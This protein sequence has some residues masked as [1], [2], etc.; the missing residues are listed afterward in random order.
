MLITRKTKV[1]TH[2]LF[3]SQLVFSLTIWG[4]YMVGAPFLLSMK[5]FIDNPA[6]I[7]ILLSLD[8]VFAVLGGPFVSW[9][10][11][12]IWTRYGRRK[13]LTGIADFLKVAIMP[14]MPFA[15]DMWT[16]LALKWLYTVISSLSSANQAL[17]MEVIP[18]SQRGRGSAFFSMQINF[19]NLIFW[20]IV[21]GRFDDVYF[22]GPLSNLMAL[23]G[24]H[25]M[26]ISA[27]LLFLAVGGYTLLGFKEIKP[28]G[29]KTLKDERKPGE[30]IVRLF[31]RSFFSDIVSRD[32]LPLYLLLFVGAMVGVGLGVLGPLLYTEQWGYSTQQLGTNVAIGA[33]INIGIAFLAGYFADATSKM[34]VYTIAIIAGLLLRIVWVAYV[35]YKPDHRPELWEILLFG[36]LG[37]IAGM[38]AG[39]VSFPLILE[40]VERN[41]LGTAGAGMG[42]FNTLVNSTLAIFIGAWIVWWSI[43]FLPQAGD[44]VE[45]V[46]KSEKTAPALRAELTAGGVPLDQVHLHAEHRPGVDGEASRHWVIRR[47]NERSAELQSQRKELQN[48]ITKWSTAISSP[49]NT[50][51]EKAALQEKISV[52]RRQVEGIEIELV[53]SAR[54]F[55]QQLTAAVAPELPGEGT[56]LLASSVQGS[57]Y[58][59]DVA[60]VEPFTPEILADL[61]K[62]LDAPD[63]ALTPDPASPGDYLGSYDVTALEAPVNGI[64]LSFNRDPRLLALERALHTAGIDLETAATK[65]SLLL[66]ILRDTLGRPVT[67][68]SFETPR[69]SADSPPRLQLV[70][71]HGPESSRLPADEL[72]SVLRD[73]GEFQAVAVSTLDPDRLALDLTLKAALP[74]A[75]PSVAQSALTARLQKLLPEADLYTVGTLSRLYERSAAAAAAKPVFLTVAQPIVKTTYADRQYDYFFS[76]YFIMIITDVFGLMVIGLITIMEKRGLV[77]RYGAEEDARR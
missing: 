72:A 19:A 58:T 37:A 11:D 20:G 54:A 6:T 49:L 1:P 77:R 41:R 32:L 68:F 66:T 51:E 30:S 76:V 69:Y 2:W 4:S 15:P 61:R 52:A 17:T 18:A 40:Y 13:V 45:L 39:T 28:P 38:I 16:L 48:D 21:I 42:L 70:L 67:A 35:Y 65:S 74:P 55:S 34:R 10:S 62:A 23:S 53:A 9:L 64:R 71:T 26:F 5:K 7:T 31:I 75:T 8:I 25:L 22:L 50:A 3:Y 56:Q 73:T 27:S 44:Y 59:L 43:W 12:R 57:T 47:Q 36:E 14:L 24:E 63:Y 60:I 46:F 29:L 33:L